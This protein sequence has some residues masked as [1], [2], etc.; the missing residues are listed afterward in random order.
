MGLR[1]SE[2]KG[3][4]MMKTSGWIRSLVGKSRGWDSGMLVTAAAWSAGHDET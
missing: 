1:G 3:R 4:G 2:A